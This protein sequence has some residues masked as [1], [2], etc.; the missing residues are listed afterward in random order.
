MVVVYSI[1]A[2]K[3]QINQWK[4]DANRIKTMAIDLVDEQQAPRSLR[5]PYHR[6]QAMAKTTN[7]HV[8]NCYMHATTK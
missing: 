1:F 4:F 5:R 6:K 7:G 2:I 8:E 3:W